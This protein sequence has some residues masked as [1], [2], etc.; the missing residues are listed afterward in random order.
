VIK[1]VL[2]ALNVV[3]FSCFLKENI[4][5]FDGKVFAVVKFSMIY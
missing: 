2:Q 3:L 1:V 4:I 5:F